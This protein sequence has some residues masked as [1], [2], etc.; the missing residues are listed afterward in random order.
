VAPSCGHAS[1]FSFTSGKLNNPAARIVGVLLGPYPMVDGRL[2]IKAG[3]PG[4]QGTLPLNPRNSNLARHCRCRSWQ[5][6]RDNE[7]QARVW[8][9]NA[10]RC[11]RF[12]TSNTYCISRV[13]VAP[14]EDLF[15]RWH[16]SSGLYVRVYMLLESG[17]TQYSRVLPSLV[18]YSA[19]PKWTLDCPAEP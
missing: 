3:Y 7:T 18:R 9:S 6:R 11:F 12:L 17:G 16:V 5:G 14:I 2:L 15:W 19:R 10:Y 8:G 13:C 1:P 4:A